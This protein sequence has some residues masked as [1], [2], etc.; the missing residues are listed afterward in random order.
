MLTLIAIGYQVAIAQTKTVIKNF[1]VA[2]E[3]SCNCNLVLTPTLKN[4]S[5]CNLADGSVTITAAG[6]QG[7]LTFQWRDPS[8]ALIST[9]KDLTNVS[10]GYYFLEVKD[11]NTPFCG[12]YYSNYTLR[13]TFD[14]TATI[15]DNVGCVTANGAISI[16]P[17]GGS[18]NY[19]YSWR[20]PDATEVK[21]KNISGL[22]VG[23]YYLTLAD[24]STG[25]V[26]NR[27]FVVQ[28]NAQLSVT[29]SSTIANTSCATPN[30]S[31][32][33]TVGNGSGQYNY[34]WY[35]MQTYWVV[36]SLKDLKGAPGGLYNAFV[37][38]KVSGCITYNYI[39]IDDETTKPQFTINNIK[40]NTN[41][42]APFNGSV[43]LEITGS[44][45]PFEVAWSDQ[46][47]VIS[48]D[49]KPANLPSGTVGF[50]ITDT[51]TKCK[52][53]V[54]V[55]SLDAIEILDESLPN[56]LL[57]IN[58]INSNSNC[59]T[60]DGFIDLTLEGP[61]TPFTLAWKG[62][63]GFTSTEEDISALPPG[64]Y[65]LTVEAGCNNPPIIEETTLVEERSKVSLAL[66]SV[67]S[68]PDDNL[69]PNAF[70]IVA[71]PDSHAK[72]LITSDQ[73]LTVDYSSTNFKGVDKLTIKAC[74]VLNACTQTVIN[75]EVA[76]QDGVVVYNA[77]APNSVGD[78]KFM[79]IDNLPEQNHVSIFN[80]WG[81][82][83]F[84][85]EK[86]DH[87]RPDKRFAGFTSSGK[88]LPTGTYLYKI[89]M[90]GNDVVTGYLS[91][92]Q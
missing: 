28:S 3:A 23:P 92:K 62:P 14:V 6:A 52:T 90:K 2:N 81:D 57:E 22:K 33:I 9:S 73:V 30:G 84:E 77:V 24:V 45:G 56:I 25:C 88:A 53:I 12:T 34:A 47:G 80:R 18:G 89:E 17:V 70:S 8:G 40:P 75:I 13:S 85:V 1:T 83:V 58:E 74:D 29:T 4:P 7:P 31:A 63:N 42:K 64:N 55:M 59:I 39:T 21:T 67:V 20:Y 82:V 41:C 10:A 69:D 86:Y 79:R 5:A 48:N 71:F 32:A 15:K 11:A 46:A 26:I 50:S 66:T 61:T 78:N 19:T 87:Q 91:L 72:A 27:S 16:N 60:S 36:A 49:I 65:E 44:A 37:T 35:S 51:G 76:G 38:D 68:D 43:D 54:S